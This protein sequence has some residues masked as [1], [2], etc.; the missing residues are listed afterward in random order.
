MKQ[1]DKISLGELTEMSKKMYEPMVKAVA[2]IKHKHLVVDAEMHVDEEQS[3]L[4]GGSMQAD[5]WGF[6]IFPAEFGTD[7]FIEFDSMINIRPRQNNRSRTV[8]SEEIRAQ[9]EAIVKEIVHE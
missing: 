9:I 2:D 4:E 3:L 6:N 7:K 8:E 5:L 1:V